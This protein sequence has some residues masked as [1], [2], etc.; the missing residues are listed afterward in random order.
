[1]KTAIG[2]AGR[3]VVPGPLHRAPCLKRGQRLEITVRDRHREVEFAP[4]S[5]LLKK[6]RKGGRRE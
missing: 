4:A 3:I 1:M 2:P 5:L 6:R